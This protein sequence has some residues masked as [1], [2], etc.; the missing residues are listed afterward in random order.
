MKHCA[1]QLQQNLSCSVVFALKYLGGWLETMINGI[2]SFSSTSDD[3]DDHDD[4]QYEVRALLA[5]RTFSFLKY[6]R[7]CVVKYKPRKNA[8]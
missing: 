2:S 5:F 3:H 7:K 4:D 1:K 8:K 6:H